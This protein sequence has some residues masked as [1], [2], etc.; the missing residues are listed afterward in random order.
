MDTSNSEDSTVKGYR[1][2]LVSESLLDA[3]DRHWPDAGRLA[4]RDFMYTGD[5]EACIRLL[6]DAAEDRR[7][8]PFIPTSDPVF[9]HAI[10]PLA[11]LE[12]AMRRG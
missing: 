1:A 11:D 9:L 3:L 10:D 2:V 6:L 5:V 4:S 12:R 7:K 8:Q